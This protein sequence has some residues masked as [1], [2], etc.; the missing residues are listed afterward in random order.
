M[1]GKLLQKL[2]AAHFM[3]QHHTSDDFRFLEDDARNRTIFYH[4]LSKLL[5]MEDTPSNFNSFVAP[6]QQ[7]MLV[8][9]LHPGPQFKPRLLCHLQ[10]THVCLHCKALL[11]HSAVVWQTCIS[12]TETQLQVLATL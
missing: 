10:P 11:H 8:S 6:L 12:N 7:V 4:T 3:L 1:S 9:L 5:F 2:E